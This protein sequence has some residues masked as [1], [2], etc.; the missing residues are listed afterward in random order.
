MLGQL[1]TVFFLLSIISISHADGSCYGP[2]GSQV[3]P[4]FEPCNSAQG[5]DSMCCATNRD[6]S[7]GLMNDVCLSNGLCQYNGTQYFR[8][9]CT[10]PTW[11]SPFCLQACLHPEV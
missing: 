8:D 6:P 5:A 9:F 1:F 7:G 2:D 4:E 3:T 11:K 10:D